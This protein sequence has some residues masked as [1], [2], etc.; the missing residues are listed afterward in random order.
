MKRL[1]FQIYIPIRGQSNLYNLCTDSVAKY[2]KKYGIDH[3]IMR[4]P[5]LRINPDMSRTQR[6][7][8]GLMKEAGYLPIF[9][10][11]WAFTYLDDYDQIAVIDSD[12]YVREN[13]PN[14]FED[15]PQEYDWGGVLE[16]DLPLNELK[17]QHVSE[18]A[19]DDYKFFEY[20]VDNND[21]LER[22]HESSLAIVEDMYKDI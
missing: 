13:A 3:V 12:I 11:E 21:S 20:I 15:L 10:K 8:I 6:N 14:I 19:L 17:H 1:I 18:T 2:C 16:R 4:E 9:E 5:K 22:L 7:K